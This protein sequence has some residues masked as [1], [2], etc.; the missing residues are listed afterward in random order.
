MGHR[1]QVPR[2]HPRQVSHGAGG[3]LGKLHACRIHGH[4]VAFE[5]GHDLVGHAGGP[6]GIVDQH[7]VD[8]GRSHRGLTPG[9]E[10]LAAPPRPDA[11]RADDARRQAHAVAEAD[12]R[13]QLQLHAAHQPGQASRRVPGAI[14][15]GRLAVPPRQVLDVA[16]EAAGAQAAIRAGF[17]EAHPVVGRE[18]ALDVHARRV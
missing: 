14:E 7:P 4:D 13:Q 2:Q 3:R 15:A 9:Q 18:A 12:R 11:P 16:Q 5:I 8:E 17:I 6:A 1:V 10:D